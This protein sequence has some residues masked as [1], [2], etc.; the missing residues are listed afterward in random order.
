MIEEDL[1][2]KTVMA[3]N[4]SL[5]TLYKIYTGGRD[6]GKYYLKGFPQNDNAS[7]NA[8]KGL[9]EICFSRSEFLPQK[10]GVIPSQNLRVGQLI[11]IVLNM[12]NIS[13]L[14]GIKKPYPVSY[15]NA[16]KEKALGTEMRGEERIQA[17]QIPVDKKYMT[18]YIPDNLF[19]PHMENVTP[20]F[21][22]DRNANITNFMKG[23]E[24]FKKWLEL[25]KEQ[26]LIK[27]YK[28]TS[29]KRKIIK[30]SYFDY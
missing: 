6:N 20:Y 7:L 22:V 16:N 12:D 5:E 30:E 24:G 27:T 28:D 23:K 13:K 21:Q 3:T 4:I 15:G 1:N 29:R 9:P 10:N 2:D 8:K 25:K 19:K 18:I 14:R 11:K 26:G 17:E